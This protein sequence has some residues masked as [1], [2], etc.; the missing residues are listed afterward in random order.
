MRDISAEICSRRALSQQTTT[1]NTVIESIPAMIA[2]ID[3]QL[4]YRMVNRAYERWQGR[5]RAELVGHG[6]QERMNSAEFESH[7]PYAQ[8]ALAGETVSYELR[9][10]TAKQIRHVA[11]TN[12]P[13]RFEDASNAGFISV[14]HDVTMEREE[15]NQLLLLSERD[16]L[17]GLLN[18]AGFEKYLVQKVR[19]GAGR[20]CGLLYIDLDHFKPINDC[21]GHAAGDE[22]L[23]EFAARLR[24]TV[25][26]TDAVA[27][28]GGD[29]FAVVVPGLHESEDGA[30]VARKVVELAQVPFKVGQQVL[31][32]S[33]SVGFAFNAEAEDGWEGLVQRADALLYK[34]KAASRARQRP[35]TRGSKE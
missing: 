25:R 21:F 9:V 22:V 14:A 16:P 18:R 1:L 28:L 32:L 29:E 10:P 31:L 12:V 8:R 26:P 7:L 27:R 4:R 33:A 5:T 34:A 2:V 11:V 20:T 24:R 15:K 30:R 13:L 17:T 6:L 23:R 19:Q 3:P 35:D